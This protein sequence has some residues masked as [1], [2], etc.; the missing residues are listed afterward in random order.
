[1]RKQERLTS[2]GRKEPVLN[3][4]QL[5]E[6]LRP[7][8]IQL[9][10]TVPL[11][12]L[13]LRISERYGVPNKE[14]YMGLADWYDEVAKLDSQERSYILAAIMTV[15]RYLK[16]TMDIG[17]QPTMEMLRALPFDELLSGKQKIPRLG[18]ERA[19]F[20]REIF[21]STSEEIRGE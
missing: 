4:P 13:S 8:G 9:A 1:M 17:E 15:A 16:R 12:A 3:S 7:L 14:A 10:D 6:R 2:A 11:R 19:A 18:Q 21:I 20:V 5:V